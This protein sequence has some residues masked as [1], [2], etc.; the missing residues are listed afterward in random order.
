MVRPSLLVV[1]AAYNPLILSKKTSERTKKIIQRRS[2]I[3]AKRFERLFRRR[4]EPMGLRVVY[5]REAEFATIYRE[6]R[7]PGHIAMMFIGHGSQE[8]SSHGIQVRDAD[9]YDWKQVPFKEL[10]RF[11]SPSMKVISL[12]GCNTE[13]MRQ[14]LE[15]LLPDGAS[16]TLLLRS[17]TESFK[18]LR[19]AV[20][21]LVFSLMEHKELWIPR[22]YPRQSNYVTA[23]DLELTQQTLAQLDFGDLIK[24]SVAGRLVGAFAKGERRKRF[25]ISGI[26]PQ[27]SPPDEKNRFSFALDQASSLDVTLQF[28]KAGRVLSIKS[29]FIVSGVKIRPYEDSL[30]ENKWELFGKSLNP[31]GIG[32]TEKLFEHKGSLTTCYRSQGLPEFSLL[33]LRWIE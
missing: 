24:V 9:I 1:D 10:L 14:E 6:I 22:S 11:A 31:Q 23:I 28:F 33:P 20:D 26:C 16:R 30:T 17:G 8:L 21:R 32:R 13:D 12:F 27:V 25:A 7:R 3:R 18:A 15:A 5:L 19:S 4:F 29:P 2:F